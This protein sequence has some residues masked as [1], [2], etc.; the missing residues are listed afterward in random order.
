VAV[1]DVLGVERLPF[2][3]GEHE[4]VLLPRASRTKLL[5]CSWRFRC[6]LS[7]PT[8]LWGSPTVRWLTFLGSENS[9][10]PDLSPS[11]RTL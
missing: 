7:A 4:A 8:T 5:S 1:H 6:V 3:G 10:V 9:S 11:R 2:P